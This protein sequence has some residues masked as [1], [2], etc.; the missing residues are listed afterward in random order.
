[1]HVF[2]QLIFQPEPDSRTYFQKSIF[3][4]K[5]CLF[6][7]ITKTH[8]QRIGI[9]ISSPFYATAWLCRPQKPFTSEGFELRSA[10]PEADVNIH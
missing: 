9:Y 6:I 7:P 8:K 5:E 2:R 3:E 10:D 4:G 1:M